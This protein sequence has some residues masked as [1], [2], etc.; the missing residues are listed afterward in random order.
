MSIAH[1]QSL[2]QMIEQLA[3]FG[4][5]DVTE[6]VKPHYDGQYFHLCTLER[7]APEQEKGP[8]YCDTVEDLVTLLEF[9][10]PSLL[11]KQVWFCESCRAIN[12]VRYRKGAGY[13]EV[14]EAL[15]RDH[16]SISPDCTNATS[17]LR[18]MNS[19]VIA[20]G[21]TLNADNTI[22]DWAKERLA[23]LLFEPKEL[24]QER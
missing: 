23:E 6:E 17:R 11:E 12:A 18:V 15:D 1:F 3:P 22:P 24:S 16:R 19:A 9:V 8:I 10:N 2:Q 7:P 20:S 5:K 21:N 13:T 14:I 4:Y